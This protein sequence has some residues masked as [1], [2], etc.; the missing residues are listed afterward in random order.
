MDILGEVLS[1]KSPVLIRRF[2][3]RGRNDG[4]MCSATLISNKAQ[5]TVPR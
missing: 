3:A 4:L 2:D 1:H 5:T